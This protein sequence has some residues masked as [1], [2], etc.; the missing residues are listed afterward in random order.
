MSPESP[1]SPIRRNSTDAALVIG[2]TAAG[3]AASLLLASL[4]PWRAH[5]YLGILSF[6]LLIAVVAVAAA[7]RY[8]IPVQAGAGTAARLHN[9]LSIS[10]I[11]LAVSTVALGIISDIPRDFVHLSDP[12]GLLAIAIAVIAVLQ[13]LSLH[14]IRGPGPRLFHRGA[15]YLLFLLFILQI[16]LGYGIIRFPGTG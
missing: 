12:H 7:R 5:T 4:R 16:L 9:I 8:R 14:A 1:G 15:G 3:I 6:L 13:G 2:I 10:F 11:G